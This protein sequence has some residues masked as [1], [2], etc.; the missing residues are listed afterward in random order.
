[1]PRKPR[2]SLEERRV[3]RAERKAKEQ[4]QPKPPHTGPKV[5]ATD[6]RIPDLPAPGVHV[7]KIMTPDLIC[8]PPK[9]KLAIERYLDTEPRDP[10]KAAELAGMPREEFRKHLKSPG[11]I[12]YVQQREEWIDR[13]AAR[14]RARARVL[15]V[16]FLDSKL[17]IAATVGAKKGDTDAIELGYERLGM[18][19]DKN[20][21]TQQQAN[22]QSRP[23]VY[24]VLEQTV[25]RTEQV[26]QREITGPEPEPANQLPRASQVEILDY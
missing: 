12:V 8:F 13:E 10:D 26:T 17:V 11:V 5:D 4:G 19:R 9:L 7:P 25:T 3:R 18:R 1:M 20:F 24:R 6:Y 23:Q 22:P 15:G 21:M 16:H 2:M 14:F